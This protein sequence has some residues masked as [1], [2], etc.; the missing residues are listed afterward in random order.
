MI[1]VTALRFFEQQHS[2]VILEDMNLRGNVWTVTVSIGIIDQKIKQVKIDA[3]TGRIMSMY[4]FKNTL[5]Q[6]TLDLANET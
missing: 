4:D 5:P 3:N 1:M 2:D 6:N